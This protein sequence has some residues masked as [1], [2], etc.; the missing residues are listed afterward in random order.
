MEHM[1]HKIRPVLCCLT[2]KQL[3]QYLFLVGVAGHGQEDVRLHVCMDTCHCIHMPLLNVAVATW[4]CPGST[5]LT[6]TM[7]AR[8]SLDV[9]ASTTPFI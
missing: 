7:L 6:R 5:I 8:V 2:R 4:V 3:I 9:I 1:S